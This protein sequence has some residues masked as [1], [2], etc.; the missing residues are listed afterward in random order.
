MIYYEN[1]LLCD[2]F[3][4]ISCPRYEEG[5]IKKVIINS[6]IYINI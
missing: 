4:F 1:R 3:S 5:A 2:N 6:S